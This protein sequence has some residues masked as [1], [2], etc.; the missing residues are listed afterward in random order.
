VLRIDPEKIGLLIGPGGKTVKAIQDE[1][2]CRIDIAEDGTV[3]ICCYDHDKADLAL[4]KVRSLTEEIRVGNIYDGKVVGIKEFGAFVEILPGKDG[5]VH[6]SELDDKYVSRVEDVVKI[7]DRIPVKVI[8]IDEQNRLKLSRKAA[9]RE[10]LAAQGAGIPG[11][12]ETAEVSETAPAPSSTEAEGT[13]IRREGYRRELS[14]RP[15]PR[16]R[17]HRDRYR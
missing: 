4:N 13:G 7:G 8:A 2:H 12:E 17:D 14:R 16:R 3:A 9:L 5:L 15:P 11:G 1:Y 10:Q 6:I